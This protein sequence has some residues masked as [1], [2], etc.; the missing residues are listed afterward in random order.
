MKTVIFVKSSEL[1]PYRKKQD[2][3]LQYANCRSARRLAMDDL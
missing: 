2:G 3:I 1:S